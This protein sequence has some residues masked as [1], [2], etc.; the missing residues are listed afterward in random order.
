M[1]VLLSGLC[2]FGGVA[3]IILGYILWGVAMVVLGYLGLMG[4]FLHG[5][6]T[7]QEELQKP[8]HKGL[9]PAVEHKEH[10]VKS[11]EP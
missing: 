10:N 5:V 3:L 2:V 7:T 11:V 1:F 8:A 4:L 9:L 6:K